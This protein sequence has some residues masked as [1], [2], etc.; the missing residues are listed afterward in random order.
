MQFDS[1]HGCTRTAVAAVAVL[2][3]RLVTSCLNSQQFLLGQLFSVSAAVWTQTPS[4]QGQ[5]AQAPFNSTTGLPSQ[6]PVSEAFC[7]SF[8][9]KRL[10]AQQRSSSQFSCPGLISSHQVVHLLCAIDGA[11]FCIHSS[12]SLQHNC[13]VCAPF[14]PADTQFTWLTVRRLSYSYRAS[15]P[16]CQL[17]SCIQQ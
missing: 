17:F 2:S 12:E 1:H 8:L 4:A 3:P 5:L 14:P 7:L 11:G 16:C 6:S 15:L 9:C 10:S 13:S